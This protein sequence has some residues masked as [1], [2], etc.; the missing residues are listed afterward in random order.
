VT[1]SAIEQHPTEEAQ[2]TNGG[3]P[4]CFQSVMADMA[5]VQ[6]AVAEAHAFIAELEALPV[7]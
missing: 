4:C 3:C 7:L 1:F 2:L 6:A 5:S